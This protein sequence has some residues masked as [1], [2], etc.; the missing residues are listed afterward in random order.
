[1]TKHTRAEIIAQVRAYADWLEQHPD[2]PAP[3]YIDMTTHQHYEAPG[4]VEK[5]LELALALVEKYGA[6]KHSSS[7]SNRWV[8]IKPLGAESAVEV[9]VFLVSPPQ[10]R[11]DEW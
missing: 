2:V 11:G 4:D 5:S 10:R 7:S 1:M 6:E 9:T 8:S 3:N